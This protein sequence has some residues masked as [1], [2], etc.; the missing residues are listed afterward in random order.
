M[1]T[2]EYFLVLV[3]LSMTKCSIEGSAFDDTDVYDDDDV[4]DDVIEGEW[5]T[6]LST[7]NI[8]TAQTM[9][10]DILPPSTTEHNTTPTYKIFYI[11]LFYLFHEMYNY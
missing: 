10:E 8:S 6:T 3:M 5:N 2:L 7:A 11:P 9:I 4:F 1:G